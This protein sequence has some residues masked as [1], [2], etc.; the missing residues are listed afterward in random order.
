[1]EMIIGHP[2]NIW[3]GTCLLG[4]ETEDERDIIIHCINEVVELIKVNLANLGFNLNW[5]MS[6]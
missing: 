4:N 6:N 5:W 3:E 1:M 2:A